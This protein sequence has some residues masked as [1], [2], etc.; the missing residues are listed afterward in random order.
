MEGRPVVGG[1]AG[2]WKGEGSVYVMQDDDQYKIGCSIDPDRRLGEIKRDRP[3]AQL[4]FDTS[5]KEMNT[6]ETA[7]QTAVQDQLGMEKAARNATDW[8]NN[9]QGATTEEVKNVVQE[10]VT[11]HNKKQ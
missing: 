9:P 1:A 11:Q 6:A 4:V 8:F 3:D 5:A 10:A 2:R 7:A